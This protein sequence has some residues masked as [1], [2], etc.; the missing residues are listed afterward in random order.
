MYNIWRLHNARALK[1][2]D[3]ALRSLNMPNSHG[4]KSSK[5]ALIK[6]PK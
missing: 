5:I 3:R 1:S 4:V 6:E 2:P